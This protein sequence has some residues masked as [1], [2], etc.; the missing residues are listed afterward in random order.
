MFNLGP[1]ELIVV[2]CVTSLPLGAFLY[3]RRKARSTQPES[4]AAIH[5]FALTSSNRALVA[6]Y[7]DRSYRWRMTGA[8]L[9]WLI[10]FGTKIPGIEM[11]GGYL[12]GVVAAE[13]T[14]ARVRPDGPASASLVPRRLSDYISPRVMVAMRAVSAT[15]VLV[16]L[17]YTF[18][19]IRMV[20]AE[21]GARPLWIATGIA[22]ALELAVEQILRIIVKKPQPA[23]SRDV[24]AA[25]DAIRSASIHA[26]AGATI[27]A[28]LLILAAGSFVLGIESSVSAVHWVVPFV[29]LACVVAA[30]VTWARM[31]H[32]HLWVVKRSAGRAEVSA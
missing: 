12:V 17:A 27:A 8:I 20:A 2:V 29:G 23:T 30:F 10:P 19:P 3:L 15:V 31:G 28:L 13:L 18:L 1:V 21:H 7:L 6:R 26:T 9:G 4:F 24:L 14:Q 5:G 25:D 22:V 32:D 16:A 11:I